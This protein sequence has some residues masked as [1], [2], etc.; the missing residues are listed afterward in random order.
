MVQVENVEPFTI[1]PAIPDMGIPEEV[2]VLEIESASPSVISL[3]AHA[4]REAFFRAK[5][6]GIE[7]YAGVVAEIFYG[8]SPAE[9]VKEKSALVGVE[10][11]ETNDGWLIDVVVR[12]SR[13][14]VLALV[15]HVGCGNDECGSELSLHCEIPG[16]HG[17][18][19]HGVVAG[20]GQDIGT[21]LIG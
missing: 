20:Q 13:R 12:A 21:D 8:L 19:S 3:E 2:A 11:S 5:L 18:Q 17:G 9:L 4:I 16:I 6:Q 14:D 1:C 10:S 7:F 15:S